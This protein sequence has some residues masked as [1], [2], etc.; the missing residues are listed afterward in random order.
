MILALDKHSALHVFISTEEAERE[1][2]AIDVQQDAFEFCD[3][4]GQRYSP[5]YTIPPKVSR[6]GPIDGADIGAFRLVA[7]GGV[8]SALPERFVE[9]A[10]GN[11]LVA[12]VRSRKQF[13]SAKLQ[14]Q[15]SIR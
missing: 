8:D 14:K 15:T 2:E 7:E 13:S 12:A 3:V 6:L 5:N 10:C 9:Q 11:D 4:R 1:L